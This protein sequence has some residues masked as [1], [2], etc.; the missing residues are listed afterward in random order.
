LRHRPVQVTLA[1]LVLMLFATVLLSCG[2][3]GATDQLTLV[4]NTFDITVNTQTGS[5][6]GATQMQVFL[7]KNPVDLTTVTWT[8]T[9]P[10]VP[11]GCFGVDQTGVPHCNAG[12][13]TSFSGVITATVPTQNSP[14]GAKATATINCTFQ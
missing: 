14:T 1:V 12:C 4:P 10:T 7:N 3:D 2:N 8:S 11:S 9:S 6:T 13:G 5:A